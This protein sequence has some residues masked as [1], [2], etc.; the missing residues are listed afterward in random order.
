MDHRPEDSPKF[1]G[2]HYIPQPL[3]CIRGQGKGFITKRRDGR[4]AAQPITA[5]EKQNTTK[6]SKQISTTWLSKVGSPGKTTEAAAASLRPTN[7][8]R[9]QKGRHF[10]TVAL[11]TAVS[12]LPQGAH[13]FFFA[14]WNTTYHDLL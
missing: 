3:N 8:S 4:E 7:A 11:S 10:P 1:L 14:F 13:F 9:H 6:A 12:L 5:T 2:I